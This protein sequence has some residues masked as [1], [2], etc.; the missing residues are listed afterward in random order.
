MG[1]WLEWDGYCNNHVGD[2][3][4]ASSTK[5]TWATFVHALKEDFYPIENYDNQYMR[6]TSLCQERDQTILQFT[7]IF[8]TLHSKLGIKDS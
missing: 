1:S 6:W 3:F 8:H 7:N 4:V 2:E 5:P